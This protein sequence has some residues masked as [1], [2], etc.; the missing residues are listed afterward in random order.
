M[1]N[2]EI[3]DN[4][5]KDFL[6]RL[7][8]PGEKV[9]SPFIIATIG[10][11]GSGR[12]T[13]ARR[14][15]QRISGTVLLQ[16]NSVRYLLRE[17]GL[18]WGENVRQIL[19]LAAEKIL[20]DGYGVVFDGNASDNDD[21]KNIQEIAQKT[22]ARIYYIR[23]KIDKEIAEEREKKKYDNNLWIS[24]FDDFRVNTTE[25]MIANIKERSTLHED[26]KSEEIPGLI[27]EINNNGSSDELDQQVDK[28]IDKI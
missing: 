19:K 11:V 27:G 1:E 9:N 13:V 26:I 14:I 15:V 22:G 20:S 4:I 8:L 5:T 18:S 28:L 2:Q 25:K 10:L 21:Q 17:A 16:A 7:E 3:L 24:N 6:S 12:T 23:I